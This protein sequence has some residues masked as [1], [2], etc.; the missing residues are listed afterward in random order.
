MKKILAV[1]LVLAMVIAFAACG[2]KTEENTTTT[3]AASTTEATEATEATTESTTAET[4]TETTTEATTVEEKDKLPETKE[5][6]LAAYTKVMNQAKADKPGFTKT[7]FQELPDDADSRVIAKGGTLVETALKVAGNFMTTEKAAKAD[8]EHKDKGSDMHSWPLY[9]NDTYGCLLTDASFLKS[10]KAEKLSDGQ[11]KLTLVTG[12]E[13]NP[14]P[15]KNNSKSPSKTGGIAGVLATSDID[16]AL[17]GGIVSAV[18]KD[19]TYS[20]IYHDCVCTVT[21]DP[22]TLHVSDVEQTTKVTISGAAK[23]VAIP[24]DITK[25][26]LIDHAHI[27]DITY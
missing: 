1:L 15:A 11:I 10:A 6:I 18:F 25:Q 8:P 27:Y 26:E 2:G 16:D 4:T 19:V 13:K 21:Y 22:E 17:S 12:S 5:E 24:L 7:Q 23:A 3:E 14:E 9:D 20:L